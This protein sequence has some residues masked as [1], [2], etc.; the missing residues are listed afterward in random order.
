MKSTRVVAFLWL[1][2]ALV[3]AWTVYR[4]V[5]FYLRKDEYLNPVSE[6]EVR[7]PLREKGAGAKARVQRN[8]NDY[9]NLHELNVTGKMAP[10]RSERVKPP[11]PP[12]VGVSPV[13]DLL[14]VIYVQF[15]GEDPTGT[16][17]FSLADFTGHFCF[18]QYKDPALE[19]S[20]EPL[21][22]AGDRLP[23]PHGNVQVKA[24]LPNRVVFL[25][26]SEP[27]EELPVREFELA[28][29]FVA[30]V[31][32]GAETST[33]PATR[34]AA[35]RGEG[36]R[37]AD[38]PEKTTE[39]KPNVWRLSQDDYEEFNAKGN[40]Y[41]G[42][43]EIHVIPHYRKGEGRPDGLRVQIRSGSALEGK[44]LRSGDILKSI[45][46]TPVHSKEQ[47]IEYAQSHAELRS[48]TLEVERLGRPLTLQ[49]SLPR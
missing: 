45:N 19:K 39:V 37:K 8:W 1:L 47:V 27:D 5:D 4:F 23:D 10:Q 15:D 42:T 41:V 6:K 13:A 46:G 29:E 43:G 18:V 26:G 48:F 36:A 44:G 12:T 31:L 9:R 35:A 28:A 32:S 17:P 3:G 22:T 7:D 2:A 40:E 20:A 16:R 38:W 11:P 21:L 33:R 14:R 34:P 49:Y 30:G 24:V 25:R